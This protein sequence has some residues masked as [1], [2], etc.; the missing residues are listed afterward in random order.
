MYYCTSPARQIKFRKE[1]EI[2]PWFKN[3]KTGL[4]WEIVNEDR[5]RDLVNS[6]DY[7][8]IEDPTAPVAPNE[9][10]EPNTPPSDPEDDEDEEE[11]QPEDVEAQEPDVLT[12]LKQKA[13]GGRR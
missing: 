12:K 8:Q 5:I 10:I 13:N 9:P 4:I 11:E 3:K 1:V 6:Q 2:M 7:E